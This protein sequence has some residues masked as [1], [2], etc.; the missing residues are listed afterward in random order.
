MPLAIAIAPLWLAAS[1]PAPQAAPPGPKVGLAFN[2][3]MSRG[4]E[5][6]LASMRE[7]VQMGTEA[8]ALSL[9][10]KE[11]E[12]GP[13][14]FDLKKIDDNLGLA[15]FVG[16]EPYVTIKIINT[17]AREVPTDLQEQAWDSPVMIARFQEFL[18]AILPRFGNR[19]KALSIANE[20]DIYFADK[21]D[22]LD[23][24]MRLYR[25]T[26]STLKTSAPDLP[27]GVTTTWEGISTRKSICQTLQQE[28]EFLFLTYYAVRPDYSLQPNTEVRKHLAEMAAFTGT[29]PWV[30][31]EFGQPASPVLGASDATQD[32]F[33]KETL[34]VLPEF[35]PRL[36]AAVYFSQV[37]F[38]PE[39]VTALKTY[40]GAQD[41]R[42]AAFLGS[43]GLRDATGKARPGLR[44]LRE[45]LRS[46]Q[47]P[48]Q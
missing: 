29:K 48:D 21:A 45:F 31:Q 3:V 39:L 13:G 19:V 2:A 40:Y 43:L 17:T 23:G 34:R 11:I 33:L 20:A 22:E 46:R 30:L 16:A 28:S 44:T 10:W 1:V 42:F 7:Q 47:S 5:G 41:P 37:D 12:T 9:N 27:I 35:A 38:S 18:R 4:E 8:M 15:R 25:A 36:K 14:M 24:F 6:F 26:K 32:A